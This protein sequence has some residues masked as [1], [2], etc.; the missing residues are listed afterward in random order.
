VRSFRTGIEKG[1]TMSAAWILGIALMAQAEG[2]PAESG[3]KIRDQILNGRYQRIAVCPLP[4]CRSDEGDSFSNSEV[5]P[6]GRVWCENLNNFLAANSRTDGFS[7]I[8]QRTVSQ[9]MQGVSLEDLADRNM[10]RQLSNRL[11]AEALVIVEVTFRHGTTAKEFVCTN[12]PKLIN[13]VENT[14]VVATAEKVTLS[15]SDWAFMGHSFEVR[16]W[17]ADRL[18]LVGFDESLALVDG[19]AMGL[20]A[21][22]T[23]YNGLIR[24]RKHPLLAAPGPY[25]IQIL[26]GNETRPANEIHGDLYVRLEPGENFGI[27]LQNDDTRP[28]LC[29]VY[30]D[31][32]NTIGKQFQHPLM[33]P[34]ADRWSLT[35]GYQGRIDGWFVRGNSDNS[36]DSLQRFRIVP[37]PQAVAAGFGQTVEGNFGMITAI[38]YTNGI[39][40]IVPVPTIVAAGSRGGSQFGIG[41]DRAD[42]INLNFTDAKAGLMLSAM[43][44]HYRSGK[45]LDDLKKLRNSTSIAN[46]APV[47]PPVS[48]H[49]P[50][51]AYPQTLN[52][53]PKPSNSGP[54]EDEIFP[55]TAPAKTGRK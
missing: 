32:V 42:A 53:R 40:G 30:I 6:Q 8:N 12:Q 41:A 13:L 33:N 34:P 27:R 7:L 26:V 22:Q 14:E 37:K 54:G 28:V 24:N 45:E 50:T 20:G 9:T 1:T 21:E 15:L 38:F 47:P 36:S 19:N 44:I 11:G 5:G 2:Q 55:S 4:I 29:A 23:Q 43:T 16:R 25:A 51:P 35:P 52:S 3:M 39:A 48:T 10:L 49:R 18:E 46:Q 17:S 31:G